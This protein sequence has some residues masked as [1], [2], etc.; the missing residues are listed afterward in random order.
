MSVHRVIWSALFVGVVLGLL[1]PSKS[2]PAAEL[3]C[4]AG[5]DDSVPQMVTSDHIKITGAARRSDGVYTTEDNSAVLTGK[6]FTARAIVSTTF[7]GRT[8]TTTFFSK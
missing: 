6:G 4:L 3:Q 8:M 7:G 5:C 2:C 1:L